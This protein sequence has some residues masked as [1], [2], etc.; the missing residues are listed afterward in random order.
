ML[1]ANVLARLDAARSELETEQKDLK[2][3]DNLIKSLQ[4]QRKFVAN[5]ISDLEI[6]ITELED[7]LSD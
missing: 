3:I 7:E 5:E 1:V 6:K 4:E 2:R